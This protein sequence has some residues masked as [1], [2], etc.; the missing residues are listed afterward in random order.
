MTHKVAERRALKFHGGN[1]GSGG[2]KPYYNPWRFRQQADSG[3]EIVLSMQI[4]DNPLAPQYNLT[5]DTL[6]PAAHSAASAAA[7]SSATVASPS[8][9]ALA[10]RAITAW[11]DLIRPRAQADAPRTIGS[12]S[13]SPLDSAAIEST[14][15]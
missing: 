15:P 7:I 10:I 8:I 13:A 1:G 3:I 6:P 4:H 12:L 14:L 9:V 2:R 11:G 5:P